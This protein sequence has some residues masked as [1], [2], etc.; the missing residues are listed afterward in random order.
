MSQYVMSDDGVV[1]EVAQSPS[2]PFKRLRA[3]S[4]L[5][6]LRKLGISECWENDDYHVTVRRYEKGFFV[7]NS[8]YVVLGIINADQS[9]RRDFRDFQA[10]K[11]QLCGRDW[12]GIELYPAESRLKDPSNEFF[13]WCVPRGVL[14]FGIPGGRDVRLAKDAIAPQR[15]FPEEG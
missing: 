14:K 4:V 7:K 1:Y 9:A 3:V 11:N 8:P 12:E 5:S 6:S 2:I 15:P 10:I 13:M